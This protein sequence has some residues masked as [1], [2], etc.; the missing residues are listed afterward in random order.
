[1]QFLLPPAASVAVSTQL[2][3]I[4]S[5]EAED[6]RTSG[7]PIGP[8]RRFGTVAAE[9]SGRRAVRLRSS[10]DSLQIT[11]SAPARGLTIRYALADSADGT[12]QDSAAVIKVGA[13]QIAQV[14][15]TSRYSVF[16]GAYPF[17]NRP[18]DDRAHHFW[19]ERRVLLP[20]PLP[21]GTSISISPAA[22]RPGFA[23]DLVDAEFVPPPD[24]MPPGGISIAAFGGD[25]TGR[26]SSRVAF[27]R[28]ITVAK[29]ASKVVYVPAGR[30]RLDGHLTVDRVKIIGAGQWHTTLAGHHIGIYSRAG[31]SSDVS[32]T[33]L[34]IESDITDRHDKAPLAAIGG[35]FRNSAFEDLYLHHAKVGIWLDGP[36]H[37]IRIAR[38]RIADQVADGINL[39]RGISRAVVEENRIRNVGD[40]GIASWSDHEPNSDIVI[41]NNQIVAP[42][43]ANGIAIY[44]GRNI[45]VSRNLIA[46]TLTEG[47]GIHLGSRFH[48]APFSGWIRLSG[49]TVVRSGSMD[50]HWHFGIGAIW[51][52]ALE[53]RISARITLTSNR[54]ED[55]GCEALQ[56]LGPH[57]IDG[58][59]IAGLSIIGK[60]RA[61]FS[62]QAPG[63][64]SV[65]DVTT[66]GSKRVGVPPY[67]A[68]NTE[69]HGNL[70]ITPVATAATTNCL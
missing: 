27:L 26:R 35:S 4:V 1:M 70:E 9:A 52:Y 41:R 5:Y 7:V 21:T 57:R 68:L 36:A 20:K 63:S 31:G 39:H 58:V 24:P 30:Y 66:D 37:D 56:L 38:V 69:E 49:N 51:I 18:N 32:L 33:G 34:A 8:D 48:S 50:P 59:S 47:G 61:I 19:D 45:E 42:I 16:Y 11:L 14:P 22:G 67:F 3:P 60:P 15:L 40:D 44:G 62:L 29:R 23:V 12:G 55:A 13:S 28:A 65:K 54:I 64:M 46:D 25:P 43:L 53:R 2:S 6:Q 10:A 17:T